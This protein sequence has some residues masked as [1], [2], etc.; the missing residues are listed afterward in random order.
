MCTKG[1]LTLKGIH[2]FPLGVCQ[3]PFLHLQLALPGVR[4][5]ILTDDSVPFAPG[6]EEMAY[7][8]KTFFPR[9]NAIRAPEEPPR[10]GE[11][12]VSLLWDV[13]TLVSRRS[14]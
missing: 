3:L 1:G 7:T 4:M 5:F 8:P 14:R 2:P 11:S 10:H 6:H 9:S 13:N 12:R